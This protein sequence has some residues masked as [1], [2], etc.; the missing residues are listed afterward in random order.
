MD[1]NTSFQTSSS[2]GFS[3][4]SI[5]ASDASS[6]EID[7][8]VDTHLVASTFSGFKAQ[9]NQ[10]MQTIQAQA[11]QTKFRECPA[12]CRDCGRKNC[13]QFHPQSL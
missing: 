7:Q 5:G 11:I 8:D 10:A 9:M 2:H 13:G 12:I 3:F 4:P 1:I 6:D